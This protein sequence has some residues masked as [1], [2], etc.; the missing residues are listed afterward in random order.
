[1]TKILL[2]MTT[3]ATLAAQAQVKQPATR[4][5][6]AGP[7][8]SI[9]ETACTACHEITLITDRRSHPRR[10]EAARRAHGIGR[11]RRPKIRSPW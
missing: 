4:P 11:R 5:L 1:M 8:K 7:A 2:G 10:L 6:P 9:V 3:I